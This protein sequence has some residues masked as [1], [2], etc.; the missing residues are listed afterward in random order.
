MQAQL[1]GA[2]STYF[3]APA[4]SLAH[5][6]SVD[7]AVIVIYFAIVIF[8]GFYLKGSANTSEEFFMAGPGNDGVDRRPELC[9]GQ[10]RVARADG[11]GRIGV[12]VRNSGDALVLD[13]RN[14]GDALSRHHH[15]AVLL[16]LE[17]QLGPGVSAPADMAT[18]RGRCRR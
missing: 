12:S 16:H 15:D 11:L 6:N 7:I 1:S 18:E 9:L 10:P 2:L 13:R 8:I 5:L 14:P 17:G 3:A 4:H